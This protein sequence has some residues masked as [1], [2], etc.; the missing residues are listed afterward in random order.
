MPP[1]PPSSLGPKGGVC[2]YPL[3]VTPVTPTAMAVQNPIENQVEGH[4]SS[5]IQIFHPLDK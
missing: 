3:G 2:N 5:S 4:N 1:E